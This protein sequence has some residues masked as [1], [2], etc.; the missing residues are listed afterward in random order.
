MGW[1][2]SSVGRESVQPLCAIACVN[3]CAQV[4]DP[5]HCAAIPL[6]GHLK[7]LHTPLGMGISAA[8]AAA[9]ALAGE[10]T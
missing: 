8:L 5:K 6:F 3:I 1:G 9:V 2:Y 10:A 7:I 4:K